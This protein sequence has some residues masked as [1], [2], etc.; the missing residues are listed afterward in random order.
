VSLSYC[1]EH[2]WAVQQIW[3]FVLAEL[4]TVEG[5]F[6]GV[7]AFLAGYFGG[8]LVVVI[9]WG[10]HNPGVAVLTLE[11]SPLP[12]KAGLSAP[13]SSPRPQ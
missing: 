2:H 7:T 9:S 3:L 13:S 4:C 5:L 6:I 11:I 10:K 1:H 8:I 12:S